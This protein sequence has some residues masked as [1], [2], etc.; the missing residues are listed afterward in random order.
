[1]ERFIHDTS[2]RLL[3][4]RTQLRRRSSHDVEQ[5]WGDVAERSIREHLQHCWERRGRDLRG[6]CKIGEGRRRIELCV[7]VCAFATSLSC[8]ILVRARFAAGDDDDDD[9]DDD[10]DDDD[11]DDDD[12]A[13]RFVA[14]LAAALAAILAA[15]SAACRFTSSATR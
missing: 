7:C 9:D 6:V 4:P 1:M 3:F 11:D 13:R 2:S 8:Y 15:S 10:N 12:D 14:A 5:R